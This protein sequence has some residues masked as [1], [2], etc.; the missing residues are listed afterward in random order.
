MQW[1]GISLGF[2]GLEPHE[3]GPRTALNFYKTPQIT[4]ATSLQ[5]WNWESPPT[6]VKEIFQKYCLR[7]TEWLP[8]APNAVS[9]LKPTFK[10]STVC[11]L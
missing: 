3:C 1:P 10:D 7:N 5:I 4:S 6:V 11:L 9:K 2:T 8:L